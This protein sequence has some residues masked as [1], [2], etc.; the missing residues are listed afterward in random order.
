[1]EIK[2]KLHKILEVETFTNFSKRSIIVETKDGEYSQFLNIEFY[3][4]KI[5]LIDNFKVGD[6]INVAIN[7]RGKENKGK[8]W[9]SINGWKIT[10][11]KEE[12]T[13]GQQNPDR[14]SS[15]FEN[16]TPPF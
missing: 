5:E 3:K 7:L 8:F 15:L 1:M 11:L 10:E 4:D 6:M 14:D 16:E 12:V 9:N 2:G 13:H